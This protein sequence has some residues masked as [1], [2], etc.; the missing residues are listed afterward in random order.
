MAE[1]M[2]SG[3]LL[4]ALVVAGMGAVRVT[5]G[6]AEADRVVALELLASAAVVACVGVAL[7]TGREL[8]LDVALVVALVGFATT[9]GWAR[10]VGR[11]GG[12]EER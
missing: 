4:T 10:L 2:G 3:L 6:P 8:Y 7:V 12:E 11:T 9:L 5:R 1:L